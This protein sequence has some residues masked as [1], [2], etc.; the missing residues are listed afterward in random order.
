MVFHQSSL[1]AHCFCQTDM[2]NGGCDGLKLRCPQSGCS[3]SHL[4]TARC[5]SCW[6]ASGKRRRKSP[7]AGGS[8]PPPRSQRQGCGRGRHTWRKSGSASCSL[9][10]GGYRVS[11]W[12]AFQHS[13][14]AFP[15][16]CLPV[17]S[18]DMTGRPWRPDVPGEEER[19]GLSFSSTRG[20][21][22]PWDTIHIHT[23]RQNHT[24]AKNSQ[25][26]SP[27]PGSRP[28]KEPLH[29]PYT[30]RG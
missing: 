16:R 3:D 5:P 20:V 30:K 29:F 24:A 4:M 6:D 7:E 11:R 26:H 25:S 1:L 14:P 18:T 28:S 19:W 13:P 15:L 17:P 22:Q 9:S 21:Y 27:F 23:S 2:S 10:P 12:A 8:G